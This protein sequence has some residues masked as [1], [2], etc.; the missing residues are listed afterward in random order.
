MFNITC[1]DKY[2]I[3][4]FIVWLKDWEYNTI[5][6]VN[7]QNTVI[8]HLLATKIIDKINITFNKK[9]RTQ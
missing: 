5:L 7:M 3:I 9:D 6:S 8:Y 4:K 1:L 2:K